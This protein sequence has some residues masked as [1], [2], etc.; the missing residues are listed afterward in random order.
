MKALQRF[1]DSMMLSIRKVFIN[2][3]SSEYNPAEIPLMKKL[4]TTMIMSVTRSALPI[5]MDEYFL[6]I[7]A[8]ISVPPEE[9]LQ[10]KRIPDAI[11]ERN[12]A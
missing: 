8:M 2:R 6:S 4:D 1:I 5:S 7:S 3:P 9:A 11:P 12:M 10:S